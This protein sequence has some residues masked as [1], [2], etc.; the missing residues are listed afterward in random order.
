MQIKKLPAHERPQEKLV[1]YGASALSTAELIALVVRT[2]NR[3]KSAVQLAEDIIGYVGTNNIDIGNAVP[4]ELIAI[5]GIGM[6]KAC[7]IIAGIEL[8]RRL[9]ASP[10]EE[11]IVIREAKD[12][13][14][15]VSNDLR[16]EKREHVIVFLLNVKC[17]VEAKITVSIGELSATSVHPREVLAPA[18]RKGAA[19]FILVHNHP[20]GDPTPSE[21]DISATDRLIESSKIVGI[22]LLDHIIIGHDSFVSLREQCSING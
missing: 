7:S 9:Q 19:G 20:S 3:D 2:G 4:E 17:Q 16:Y 18:I 13:W 21:D 1:Y 15:M 6:S 11:R 14:K 22:K 5:D 12:V 10:N 8:A